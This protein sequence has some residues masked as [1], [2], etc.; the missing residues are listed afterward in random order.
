MNIIRYIYFNYLKILIK[1]LKNF[2][3]YFK[4]FWNPNYIHP[5]L[6]CWWLKINIYLKRKL[7]FNFFPIIG[8][9]DP[10]PEQ[11]KC[12]STN[13]KLVETLQ[14]EL[15]LVLKFFKERNSEV[16]THFFNFNLQMQEIHGWDKKDLKKA[17]LELIEETIFDIHNNSSNCRILFI[18]C[19][20]GY[21]N[22][23]NSWF[24]IGLDFPKLPHEFRDVFDE[25]RA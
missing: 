23:N 8:H 1:Y 25:K 4:I 14:L 21:K 7:L 2:L 6:K 3:E 16:L 20:I 18:G 15:K 17:I 12:T 9:V 24:Q 13:I 5:E 11:K 10:L 22:S 19:F